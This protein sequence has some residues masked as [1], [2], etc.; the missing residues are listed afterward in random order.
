MRLET[1][2]RNALAAQENVTALA[3][4][5]E[6]AG[7]LLGLYVHGDDA[8][9]EDVEHAILT[10]TPTGDAPTVDGP[11]VQTRAR[12]PAHPDL[13]LVGLARRDSDH[14]HLRA[15]IREVATSMVGPAA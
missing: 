8:L 1:E 15:W 9:A 7:L 3:C 13:V 6:S 12:V 4:I 2:M 11:W 14:A 5:D 10:A